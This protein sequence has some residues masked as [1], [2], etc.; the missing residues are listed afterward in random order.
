MDWLNGEL[1]VEAIEI[2]YSYN[3]YKYIFIK[4]Y[5][6]YIYIIYF[7]NPIPKPMFHWTDSAS[8][9]QHQSPP[10]WPV[11]ACG[12]LRTS[13]GLKSLFFN[14]SIDVNIGKSWWIYK[15]HIF[16]RYDILQGTSNQFRSLGW[17]VDE[18]R[19]PLSPKR[20]TACTGKNLGP[21][22]WS[23]NANFPIPKDDYQTSM[24]W[25]CYQ[26]WGLIITLLPCFII[27]VALV[28]TNP[29][30]WGWKDN[31]ESPLVNGVWIHHE[32]LIHA[33]PCCICI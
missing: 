3:I 25:N 5:G 13:H 19:A 17:S 33:R 21:E 15:W 26:T 16:H 11:K 9:R 1:I 28:W 10:Q 22:V 2:W 18:Q 20:A 27:F 23:E 30:V 14:R 31:L 6:K 12:L 7:Q 8:F 29:V 32:K 24:F 4:F